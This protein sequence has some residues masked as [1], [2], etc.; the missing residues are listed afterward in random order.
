MKIV[1]TNKAL[2]E[3]DNNDNVES[4]FVF[5]SASGGNE[6]TPA[7]EWEDMVLSVSVSISSLRGVLFHRRRQSANKIG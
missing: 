1:S 4:S 5:T 2:Y 6:Q 3:N 7:A